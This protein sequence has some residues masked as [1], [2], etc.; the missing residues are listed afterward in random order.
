[1]EAVQ[2][3]LKVGDLC[4]GLGVLGG[5]AVVGLGRS[6]LL[7]LG[8]G[9]VSRTRRRRMLAA[10]A[11]RAGTAIR[12][13]ARELGGHAGEPPRDQVLQ[14]LAGV[15]GGVAGVAAPVL[16]ASQLVLARRHLHGCLKRAARRCQLQVE[17]GRGRRRGGGLGHLGLEDGP[18]GRELVEPVPAGFGIPT[19]L[20]QP[21]RGGV[22]C[23]AGLAQGP[24]AGEQRVGPGQP[25]A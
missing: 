17:Q 1:M 2:Q 8:D 19:Q 23:R 22:S 12:E 24:L 10:A 21:G 15:G 3:P 20:L 25:L 18:L 11:D 4:H 5:E 14:V 13:P 6:G 9:I 16:E 7:R